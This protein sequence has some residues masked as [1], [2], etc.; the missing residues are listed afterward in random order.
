[1]E[2]QSCAGV[3]SAALGAVPAAAKFFAGHCVFLAGGVGDEVPRAPSNSPEGGEQAPSPLE[4]AGGEV[5]QHHKMIL[6]PMKDARQ[7]NIFH[8][9]FQRN[10]HSLGVHA[11]AFGGVADAEHRNAFAGDEAPFTEVLKGVAASVMSGYH[12]EA[13]GAAVHG[14]ELGVDRKFIHAIRF[15]TKIVLIHHIY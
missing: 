11:D 5:I 6:I 14:V 7:R 15:Q 3:F 4:R 1:L 9:L 8:Q 10:S 13:G 12:A 2:D